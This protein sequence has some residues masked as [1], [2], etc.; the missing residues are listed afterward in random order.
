MKAPIKLALTLVLLMP[1]LGLAALPPL[2]DSSWLKSSLGDPDLVVLDI[3]ASKDYR[4]FHVPGAV[5]AS[6]ERWR[7]RG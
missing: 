2:V 6:Y 1:V 7:T 3:Q 4:R 5:N